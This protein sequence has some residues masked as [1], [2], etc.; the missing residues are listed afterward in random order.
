MCLHKDEITR[1]VDCEC[2]GYE[3]A[4]PVQRQHQYR[5]LNCQEDWADHEDDKCQWTI[6][7]DNL[8]EPTQPIQPDYIGHLVLIELD[9]YGWRRGWLV[10]YPGLNKR[11]RVVLRAEG[12]ES[13][14]VWPEAT[15]L[16]IEESPQ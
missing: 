9:K 14:M 6:D 12:T 16:N 13:K 7:L 1:M 3:E 15:V 11:G 5:C 8:V 4:P 2:W 10:E